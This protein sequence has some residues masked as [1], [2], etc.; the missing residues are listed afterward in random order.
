MSEPVN[1][2]YYETSNF[3][4]S[5][6]S[7]HKVR[8]KG[9]T[10]ATAE[11]AFHA[12]KFMDKGL[13][14]QIIQCGSPLEA[15]KLAKELKSQRRT[16][17][18]DVKVEVLTDIIREKVNQHQEV[19]AALLATDDREIIEINKNDE[20]WGSGSGGNGQNHTGKIL[21]RIRAEL[22]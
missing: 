4:F 8:Y 5:N 20:F 21:M 6:F 15:W 2:P 18:N 10:Y 11:H 3:C 22:Q 1:I 16:D 13:R 7:A 14:G 19:K 9:V 17:W 12:Q